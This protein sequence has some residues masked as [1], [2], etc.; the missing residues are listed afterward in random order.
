MQGLPVAGV[1]TV[2]QA[3]QISDENG[4]NIGVF[5]KFHLFCSCKA[6]LHHKTRRL[7]PA[8]ITA[9]TEW[10]VC[11]GRNKLLRIH[12]LNFFQT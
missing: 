6:S 7:C 9:H 1:S 5:N 10:L 2:M 12:Q 4:C 8:S 11:E 3:R